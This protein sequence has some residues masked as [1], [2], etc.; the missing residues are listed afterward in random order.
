M[1]ACKGILSFFAISCDT[2]IVAVY[3]IR[4][5]SSKKSKNI[6]PDLGSWKNNPLNF[7]PKFSSSFKNDYSI[8]EFPLKIWHSLQYLANKAA[9]TFFSQY[10]PGGLERLL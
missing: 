5:K 8:S 4:D 6:K 7:L 1:N 2:K 9:N 3:L 10:D